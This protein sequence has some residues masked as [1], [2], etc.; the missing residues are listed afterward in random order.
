MY[1]AL[2]AV[3]YLGSLFTLKQSGDLEFTKKKWTGEKT[4][5]PVGPPLVRGECLP[6]LPKV[7]VALSEGLGMAHHCLH[8]R[9]L[10]AWWRE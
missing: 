3:S 1:F 2:P 5:D 7:V 10:G 6:E 9:L 8:F 4:G